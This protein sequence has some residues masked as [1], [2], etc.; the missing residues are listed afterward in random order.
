M[1]SFHYGSYRSVT[2]ASEREFLGL[3]V[4]QNDVRDTKARSHSLLPAATTQ[5]IVLSLPDS[6]VSRSTN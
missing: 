1:I 4:Y 2:S 5:T 6:G 3:H